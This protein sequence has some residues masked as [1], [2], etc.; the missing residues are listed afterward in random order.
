M[1]A[2]V[3][4]ATGF[5]GTNLVHELVR[6]GWEVRA[7]GLP[8]STT[9]YIEDLPVEIM[10]GD[11]RI[12]DDVDKAVDGMDAV[13]HVAGDTSFWKRLFVRQREVNVD[14]PKN[15]ARACLARGVKRMIHTST[16]DALGYNPDGL[17]DE[18]WD[19]Y[20]YAGTGYNYADTKR[21]G[22]KAVLGFV[23][24]GLDVVVINP[25]SMIGPF[26]HTLQFGRLFGDIRDGKV[27]AIPPGG[28]PW[29]HVQEVA[30]AHIQAFHRG[31]KGERYIAGG[32]NETYKTVFTLIAE[33]MGVKPP[34]FV[35]P[36]WMTVAYGYIMEFISEFTNKP[37][38][39]NPGQARYMSVFPKYDSSKA[40][41]ELGFKL[42][43]IEE[44]VKDAFNWY[45]ENGFL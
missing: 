35:M 32:I 33:T 23:D 13:F 37:P 42:R 36:Y 5:L 10:L 7:F 29:A 12:Y 26:D 25:G 30:K 43:P 31:R 21:E 8:G 38:D 1:K 9:R 18:T 41:R 2:L 22:E 15:V 20:N 39:L 28:A 17:A 19:A 4:G 14:G 24:E 6:Q 44:M 40:V 27:P 16:V 34:R 45:K 3:T 11:V